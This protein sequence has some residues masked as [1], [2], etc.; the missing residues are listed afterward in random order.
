MV[1]NWC[2]SI[3]LVN[4]VK[5]TF[6]PLAGKGLPLPV[7]IECTLTEPFQAVLTRVLA[8]LATDEPRY[9]TE[10]VHVSTAS[11]DLPLSRDDLDLPVETIGTKYG[12]A[13]ALRFGT[14]GLP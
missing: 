14:L 11:A 9:Q 2:V 10:P 13:F 1:L 12:Y 8:R 3:V 5:M 6:L 4:L 7:A